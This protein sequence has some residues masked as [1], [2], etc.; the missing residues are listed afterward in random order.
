MTPDST[1]PTLVC[2]D[3]SDQSRRGLQAIGGLLAPTELVVLT[4]WQP[5]VT[6]LAETG[7]FGVFALDDESEVDESEEKAARDAAEEGAERGRAA[8][9]RATARV[10]EAQGAPW[11]KIIE[12]ANEIDAGLIVCGTR[13]RGVLKT[14]LLGSV[15]HAVLTHSGR[16]VLIAPA[17]EEHAG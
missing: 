10:E 3:G 9:H 15:S 11:I 8:G 6:K 2:Y 16:P 13:G 1:K 17:P 5:L 7:S 12:V 4:V 14:A